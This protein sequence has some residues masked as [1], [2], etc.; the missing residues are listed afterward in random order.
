[1]KAGQIQTSRSALSA[2]SNRISGSPPATHSDRR[3]NWAYWS[4][5]LLLTSVQYWVS[6]TSMHEIRYEELAESVRNVFWLSHRLVYDGASSNIGWY[7]VL[8]IVYKLFGFSLNSAKFVR[9]GLHFLGLTCTA[10]MLRRCMG[11]RTAIVPL[12]AIGLSP[13][14]LYMNSL[15]TSNGID[16]PYAAICLWLLFSVC[17]NSRAPLELGKTFLCGVVAMV[18]AMSYPTFLLYWP[19]LLLVSVWWIRQDERYGRWAWWKMWQALSATAGLAVPLVAACAYLATPRSLFWDTATGG[20]LFRGGGIL[21]FDPA[22]LRHSLSV[23]LHDLLVRGQS[24]YFE[25]TR[26]D[27]SG[28]LA[29]AALCCVGTTTIYLWLKRQADITILLA[30]LLLLAVN[31]VVPS[32]S[33]AGPPGIRR[34]TGILA[35]Y[36]VL[37]SVAWYFLRRAAAPSSMIWV[38][39]T[40]VLICLLV[41]L[42]GALKL[43]SLVDDLAGDSNF[44]N[45]DWFAIATTPT[46]SLEGLLDQVDKGQGLSCPI[47]NE[48]RII[49]CRYQEVYA[50]MAGYRLW[51]G[52]ST[53][54]IRALDWKTGRD[55]ILTPSL[56]TNYY[57]PH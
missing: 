37:F 29:I 33:I 18:A 57:F 14:L 12:V 56:W 23:V 21:G 49:P 50:A 52:R 13:T 25:V 16:L 40:G 32:L 48:R 54:D 55:I 38:R 39:R 34:S 5:P 31:L 10:D 2:T 53:A 45:D 6:A 43:P 42:D 36:F 11:A 44:R 47:D 9:L 15:Q 22:M 41:P 7:G 51:N 35:A 46:K 30:A 4:L 19:S 20:G 24:Y 17:P 3:L 28:P 26:P 27:F 8:L 1:M